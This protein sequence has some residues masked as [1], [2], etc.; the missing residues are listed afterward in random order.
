MSSLP[1]SHSLDFGPVSDITGNVT[2][3]PVWSPAPGVTPGHK[4]QLH[5]CPVPAHRQHH[6]RVPTA[7]SVLHFGFT[8]RMQCQFPNLALLPLAG[9]S[10]DLWLPS[11][12]H[13]HKTVFCVA[14]TRCMELHPQPPAGV[15]PA[16]G[17]TISPACNPGKQTKKNSTV[18][19]DG[20]Q[21]KIKE[22]RP[23]IK[24]SLPFPDPPP[25]QINKLMDLGMFPT[26]SSIQPAQFLLW[27]FCFK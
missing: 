13:T 24:T 3:P 15:H 21:W 8:T 5:S 16:P 12:K 2:N 6:N 27:F 25:S 1:R 19:V 14:I 26:Q 9:L 23:V 20:K 7:L 17:C 4:G 18:K 22:T 10:S 11:L